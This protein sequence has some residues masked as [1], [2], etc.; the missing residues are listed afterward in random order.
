MM[1]YIKCTRIRSSHPTVPGH[2]QKQCWLKNLTWFF[3]CSAGFQWFRATFSLNK[4]LITSALN[5]FLGAFIKCLFF[6]KWNTQ[7]PD[8]N[9]RLCFSYLSDIPDS[10]N[11]RFDIDWTSIRHLR[12]RTM[13][14]R[15]RSEGLCYLECLPIKNIREDPLVKTV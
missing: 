3:S 6:L 1:K 9:M 7:P 13:S 12:V 5:A 11:P 14:N 10:K 15:C 2:Q 4:V 8:L